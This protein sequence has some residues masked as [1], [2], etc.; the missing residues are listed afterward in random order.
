M[1]NRLMTLGVVLVA[2]LAPALGPVQPALAEEAAAAEKIPA[3]RSLPAVTVITA[4]RRPVWDRII[5]SGLISAVE[6]VQVVPLI[7]GQAVNDLL[8]D[9]GDWV[10]AGEVLA[11]LSSATLELQQTEARAAVASARSAIAQSEAQLVEAQAGAAEAGRVLDRTTTLRDNGAA[12]QAS[13]DAVHAAKIAADAR[14]DLASRGLEAAKAQLDLAEARLETAELYL[15][16][17]GVKA[18]VAG[19]IVARNA[20]LG[21]IASTAGQPMFVITRDGALELRAD[22][23]EADVLRLA[24]G[25]NVRL[26]AA[27]MTKPL[28]GTVRLV[29]PTIDPITRL[30]RVRISLDQPGGLRTGMFAEAEILV[31][32]S[33]GLIVPITALGST[34]DGARTVMRVRDGVIQAVEVTIGIRDDGLVEITKG[35]VEGDLVIARAG[36]FVRSGDRV[37]PV[38]TS[39]PPAN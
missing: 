28:A 30:G 24:P 20:Q 26:R 29:E 8:V 11:R 31:A 13:W 34:A 15:G 12:P 33:E 19:E 1:M 4:E 3:S 23:A 21:T 36:T 2:G 27:G 16:R 5:A 10:E 39:L 25:M 14:V 32:E 6:E 7:E 17:T 22:V 18:P 38:P 9:V 35:L 37:N